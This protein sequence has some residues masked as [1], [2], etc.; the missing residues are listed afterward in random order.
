M[1]REHSARAEIAKIAVEPPTQQQRLGHH[2]DQ[3]RSRYD[4]PINEHR[5]LSAFASP[6][7]DA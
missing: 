5:R 6:F 3:L 7:R 2:P 4:G 1:G